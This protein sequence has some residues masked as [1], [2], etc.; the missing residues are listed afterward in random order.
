MLLFSFFLFLLPTADLPDESTFQDNDIVPG[1]TITMHIWRQDGW[2]RLV[3]A[4]AKGETLKV[5]S[6]TSVNEWIL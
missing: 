3:A 6:I 2:G 5:D 1:G 4:A